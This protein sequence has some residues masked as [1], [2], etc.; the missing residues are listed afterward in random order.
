MAD[1]LARY[2]RGEHGV[3]DELVAD[4]DAVMSSEDRRAEAEAVARALMKRVRSASHAVRAVLVEAGALVGPEEPPASQATLA[5]LE[6]RFG[7][8]PIALRALFVECGS[9]T[10]LPPSA[11]GTFE[12]YGPNTFDTST[13]LLFQYR[14]PVH[15]DGPEAFLADNLGELEDYVIFTA[16]LHEK[17]NGGGGNGYKLP[18]PFEDAKARLDP[19][20]DGG[21]PHDGTF[22]AYLRH[23]FRWGGFPGLHF[24]TVFEDGTHYLLPRDLERIK[25][26]PRAVIEDA[27]AKLRRNVEPF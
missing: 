2:D 3:W 15:V 12:E 11:Y 19:D 16:D 14:D 20:L 5:R 8:L 24:R 21:I 22:V 26:E 17:A 1:L 6:E 13:G 7:P 23:A 9:L 10:L 4:A 18:F 27:V 25:G